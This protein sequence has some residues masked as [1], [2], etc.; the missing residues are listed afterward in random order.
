V[1][2][3]DIERIVERLDGV[4]EVAVVAGKK[5]TE[6]G[7]SIAAFCVL[8]SG[9]VLDGTQVRRRCADLMPPYAIPD[10]VR[11]VTELPLLASGKLNRR[12]LESLVA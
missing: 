12:A 2:L 9:A 10:E 4:G 5:E 6:R 7:Q 1:M 8:R 3:S 11:I